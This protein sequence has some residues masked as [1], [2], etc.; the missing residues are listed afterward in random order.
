VN[1]ASFAEL[2]VRLVNS[3]VCDVEADPL[4]TCEAFRDFVADRQFL[5]GP[6]TPTDLDRLKLLR[7]DLA[8]VFT[9]AVGGAEQDAVNRLNALMMVHPVHPVLVSHD[10]QPWHVPLSESGSVTDRYA[11]ATV[12]SLTL[13]LSQYGAQRFG[14]CTI[15]SCDR[16]Y[17]DGSSN[18]SRRYCAF[19]SATRG[20]VTSL[21]AERSAGQSTE[22]APERATDRAT[23]RPA[24]RAVDRASV[25]SAAS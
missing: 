8:T 13:L 2:A 11:A 16:V 15:A 7:R 10:R 22:V 5:A 17:F 25:A 1:L 3:A 14:I 9:C 23:D 19:H 18:K 6:V 4:R 12:I 24:G 20:N 21:R